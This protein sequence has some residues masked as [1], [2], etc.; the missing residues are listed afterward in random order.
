[1]ISAAVAS[2][3]PPSPVRLICPLA[4]WP[5]TMPIGKNTN[6][7][8]SAAIAVPLVGGATTY[9]G[10][11]AGGQPDWCGYVTCT[12][13]RRGRVRFT[14]TA[15]KLASGFFPF[16][17]RQRRGQFG[18]LGGRGLPRQLA[19]LDHLRGRADGDR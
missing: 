12:I 19:V 5:R 13:T 7:R 16:D 6:T 17:V 18:P 4:T 1:M 10:G 8:I 2:P 9:C 11:A 3:L 14:A 15:Q